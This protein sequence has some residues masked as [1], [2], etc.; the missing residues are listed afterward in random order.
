MQTTVDATTG[1]MALPGGHEPARV[2]AAL[3]SNELATGLLAPSLE[4]QRLRRMR[5]IKVPPDPIKLAQLWARLRSREGRKEWVKCRQKW[6]DAVTD[7]ARVVEQTL[8]RFVD[9][10][11]RKFS[12][13]FIN[14][15]Q[16][17]ADMKAMYSQDAA[18]AESGA[19]LMGADSIST[20]AA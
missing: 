12:D 9:Y 4:L 11:V 8:E 15:D 3:K 10:P 13:K 14:F 1:A 2:D 20:T 19:D 16:D 18:L 5:L 17:I 6:F 7:F